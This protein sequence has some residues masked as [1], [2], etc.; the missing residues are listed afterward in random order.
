VPTAFL[1]RLCTPA[2]IG[3]GIIWTFPRG[4]G[5]PTSGS[6]V[7]WN[8]GTNSIVHYHVVVDELREARAHMAKLDGGDGRRLMGTVTVKVYDDGAMSI[9]GPTTEPEWCIAALDHA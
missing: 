7:I 8:A 1:R 3:A 5:M 2:T 6:V 4:L 9:E